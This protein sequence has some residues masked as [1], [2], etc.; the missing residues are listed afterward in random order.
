VKR[1][2]KLLLVL[3][4][5][6]MVIN[7]CK[8]DKPVFPESPATSK[9]TTGA[10]GTTGTTGTTGSTGNTGNTVTTIE[11]PDLNGHWLT[12]KSTAG[13]FDIAYNPQSFFYNSDQFYDYLDIDAAKKTAIFT[14]KNKVEDKHTYTTTTDKGK[15]YILFS[16]DPYFRSDNFRIEI[17]NLTPTETTW[18]IIDTKLVDI[19]GGIKGYKGEIITYYK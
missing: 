1:P 7:A 19:G 2:Y 16:N 18:S 4:F 3:L 11:L 9:G 13:T 12:K 10:T 17:T 14:I 15:T 8:L 5:F 6:C